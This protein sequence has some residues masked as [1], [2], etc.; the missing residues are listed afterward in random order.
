ML[1]LAAAKTDETLA[2]AILV[3]IANQSLQ[4]YNFDHFLDGVT[5]NEQQMR[6]SKS[7]LPL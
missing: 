6:P 3:T 1:V 5:L 2:T 7:A 4:D